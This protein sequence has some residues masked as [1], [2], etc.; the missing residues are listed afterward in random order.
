MD[1]LE[2]LPNF[3]SSKLHL[4]SLF[5][6]IAAVRILVVQLYSTSCAQVSYFCQTNLRHFEFKKMHL[7]SLSHRL[8]A[9]IKASFYLW[10]TDSLTC[11]TY[12][13]MQCCECEALYSLQQ[14]D[15]LY[16]YIYT[17]TLH[18][19][20]SISKCSATDCTAVRFPLLQSG[21][22]LIVSSQETSDLWSGVV[23]SWSFGSPTTTSVT[24]A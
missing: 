15:V 23:G 18:F 3:L 6:R 9:V 5:H 8:A 7:V 12:T 24:Q 20:H 17:G 1:S 11:Y 14:Y 2:L 21:D 10:I 22:P 13:T 19:V 16:K 4:V